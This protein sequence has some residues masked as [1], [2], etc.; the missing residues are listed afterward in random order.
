MR[1]LSTDLA[2]ARDDAF[3]TL[4]VAMSATNMEEAARCCA[5]LL[6]V[7]PDRENLHRNRVMVAYG[8]GKDSSYTLAFVRAMQLL[9]FREH[10]TT[11]Q[12]RV[13][14]NR[15]AGMPRAVMENIDRAYQALQ[16]ADDPDCELLL[17][18]GNEVSAFD[19]D[20]PQR[21]HVVRR[22][23]LDILMTGHRTFADGR[24]TFCNACNLSVINS[25]G[26]AAAHGDGADLIITGDSQDEQRQ[27]SAWVSRLSRRIAPSGKNVS[28]TG[29]GRLLSHVDGIAQS[30]FTDIHGPEA[31]EERRVTSDVPERMRFFSIYSETAYRAGDHMSLLTDFLGFA[32]DD[33]AFSFTESDCGNPAL[34]AHLRGL[35]CER[36]YKR[37]YDEG[38]AE[39]VDF[40]LGLM[41]E[42]DF[43]PELVEHMR[44]RYDSPDAA[45]RMRR[46]AADYA[47]ETF[48]LT[49]E[50]LVCLVYSPFAE[51]AVGLAQFLE[52]EHPALAGQVDAIQALLANDSLEDARLTVDLCRISGLELP[53]LRVLH[54]RSLRRP[55]RDAQGE[56][57]DAVLAGD[58]HKAVIRTRHA[59]GGPNTLEQISGR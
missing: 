9:L 53:Q 57:I 22:N 43:P 48:G 24:P 51:K 30:Y 44:A 21:E 26:V 29:F 23:R 36:V 2:T 6:D 40:A 50:Q 39:Y 25:F 3:Q 47:M 38:L 5:R 35:K 1:L 4:R 16:L 17:I 28:G 34:M 11:F 37:S 15:H 58:P 20:S 52:N 45:T 14:T 41:R 56:A 8:G 18:D 42:K 55:G 10:G 49:E 31:V 33:V 46:A 32:F 7:L 13:A 27:Y 12:M 54:G 19:V 59:P